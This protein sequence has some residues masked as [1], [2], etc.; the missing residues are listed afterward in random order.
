MILTCA[1]H[2]CFNITK[3]YYELAGIL[4]A[5]SDLSSYF[6]PARAIV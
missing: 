3:Q 4:H 5:Y 6:F 2:H 1:N